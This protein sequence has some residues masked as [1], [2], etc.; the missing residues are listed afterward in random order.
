MAGP[1]GLTVVGDTKSPFISDTTS[2]NLLLGANISRINGIP[3]KIEIGVVSPDFHHCI[4]QDDLRILMRNTSL[5]LIRLRRGTLISLNHRMEEEPF[6]TCLLSDSQEAFFKALTPRGGC[7][8]ACRIVTYDGSMV[9]TLS[10]KLAKL[11]QSLPCSFSKRI[12]RIGVFRSVSETQYES[13]AMNISGTANATRT[14]H[15]PLLTA[16]QQANVGIVPNPDLGNTPASAM[17]SRGRPGNTFRLGDLVFNDAGLV[18]L[19]ANPGEWSSAETTM[20]FSVIPDQDRN[21]LPPPDQD[22]NYLPL[23]VPGTV[24]GTGESRAPEPVRLAQPQPPDA[25]K[26]KEASVPQAGKEENESEKIQDA[27]NRIIQQGLV[28][29]PEID[30]LGDDAKE[31][32]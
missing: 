17:N 25:P 20:S 14:D 10:L 31:F 3:F 18:S 21:Y 5:A 1:K 27:V 29:D 7:D 22:R 30:V 28:S 9:H 19:R 16:Q 26:N 8:L 24:G 13:E 2:L 11:I 4:S 23:I 12:K 32:Q 15:V 6:G